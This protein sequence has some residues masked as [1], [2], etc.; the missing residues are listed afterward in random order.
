VLGSDGKSLSSLRMVME[1]LLWICRWNQRVREW[2]TASV[3]LE[4]W[5]SGFRQ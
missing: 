2:L 5:F 4:L 1:S 3:N